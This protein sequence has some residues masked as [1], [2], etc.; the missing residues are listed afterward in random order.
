MVCDGVSQSPLHLLQPGFL[1]PLGTPVIVAPS[2]T[3]LSHFTVSGSF[4]LRQECSLSLLSQAKS[5]RRIQVS[6]I[7]K[8]ARP[9]KLEPNVVFL[10]RTQVVHGLWL[11]QNIGYTLFVNTRVLRRQAAGTADLSRFMNVRTRMIRG[12]SSR[13]ALFEKKGKKHCA[14]LRGDLFFLVLRIARLPSY[15]AHF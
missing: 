6:I 5:G 8:R 10:H 15:R 12:S 3:S 1:V 4:S 11:E 13:R 14:L 7:A 2:G 9:L